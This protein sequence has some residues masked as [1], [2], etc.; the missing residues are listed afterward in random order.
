MLA[1]HCF[2]TTHPT[3]LRHS[4]MKPSFS[5]TFFKQ[6]LFVSDINPFLWR[7]LCIY[8]LVFLPFF[9]HWLFFFLLY[10]VMLAHT[11]ELS[12]TQ[13]SRCHTLF[14]WQTNPHIDARS[15]QAGRIKKNWTEWE[16]WPNLHQLNIYAMSRISYMYVA[17]PKPKLLLCLFFNQSSISSR[18]ETGYI[19]YMW[20]TCVCL[21]VTTCKWP[22]CYQ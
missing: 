4:V 9:N 8:M 10:S 2:L 12:L 3:G 14:N 11:H 19:A 20:P 22:I 6:Y 16:N 18:L 21:L 7:A 1:E 17:C 13:I 5:Q 15:A